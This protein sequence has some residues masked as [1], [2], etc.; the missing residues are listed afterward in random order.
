MRRLGC[1]FGAF[2]L[3]AI[4]GFGLVL[5]LLASALGLIVGGG[6]GGGGGDALTIAVV[7]IVVI[8][9]GGAFTGQGFR[10]I[11]VPLDALS[12]AAARVAAG[13]LA[14]RVQ[15]PTRGP[16]PLRELVRSFNTMAE[17][18][19]IDEAQRR[20]LLADVSHELRTPLAVIQGNVEAMVD[21]V[22]P[23]DV[24]HLNG[25][26]EETRVLTRLV[27]DLRT[28]A[29]AE[30][31][32]LPLHR[33]PT[34]VD[35]LITEAA[36]SFRAQAERAGVSLELAIPDDLPLTDVDPVRIREVVS[37]LV[38]NALRHTPSGG[39]IRV[40]AASIR[41]GE[42]LEVAV[43]DTGSGI[44]PELLAHVFERFAKGAASRGSGLGLAI[45]MDLVQ[46]HGGTIA[47][48]STPGS[49]TTIRFELPVVAPAA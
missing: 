1:L 12:E 37:N 15:E 21:G 8:V 22:H 13:D 19:A 32:T 48:E 30:A 4:L 23:A 41:G 45:A 40:R 10:R 43:A 16:R 5:W 34:D 46:A 35:A 7:L 31:G 11:A 39:S 38:S 26:L 27:E 47:A 36:R 20:D 42:A 28:V 18:L 49:G 17:R 6:N 25:V 44:E 29:L 33:E 24:E 3:L 14:A 2:F 9:L